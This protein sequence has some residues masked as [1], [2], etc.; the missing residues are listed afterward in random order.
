MPHRF[1]ELISQGV[2]VFFASLLAALGGAVHYL[3]S[4]DKDGLPF[5]ISTF[6]LEILT[7][8]FV[9]IVTFM[10]CDSVGWDWQLTAAMVA[11]SGHMGARALV[12]IERAIVLPIIRRHEYDN[13][14]RKTRAKKETQDAQDY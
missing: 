8:G 4:I 3:N 13:S 2:P 10:L 11:I 1:S 9:G 14:K 7:S 5:R 6:I 12:I